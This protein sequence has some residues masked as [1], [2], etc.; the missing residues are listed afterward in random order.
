[1]A[2][3][4]VCG[5]RAKKTRL[6]F[7][8]VA[9]CYN[10]QCRSQLIWKLEHSLPLVWVGPQDFIEHNVYP[11]TSEG[12]A[13]VEELKNIKAGEFD[14]LTSIMQDCLWNGDMFNQDYDTVLRYGAEALENKKIKCTE[15][16]NL[17]LL[18]GQILFPE[19][20][21][22]LEERIKNG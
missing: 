15:A 2:K 17:P 3:C 21:K 12:N 19:N 18:L 9:L 8:S 16:K 10:H 14:T 4:I 11:E 1:M 7:G 22:Y 20:Q 13:A 5:K 6:L